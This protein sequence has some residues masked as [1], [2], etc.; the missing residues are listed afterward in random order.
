MD[1]GESR[2]EIRYYEKRSLWL[3]QVSAF[4][5]MFFADLSHVHEGFFMLYSVYRCK[6]NVFVFLRYS[7]LL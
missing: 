7:V 2:V 5:E 3:L 1:T 4:F 6:S